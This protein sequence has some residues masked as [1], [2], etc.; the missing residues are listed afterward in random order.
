MLLVINRRAPGSYRCRERR[1]VISQKE[2][3]LYSKGQHIS[4]SMNQHFHDNRVRSKTTHRTR[5]AL[6]A[7]CGGEV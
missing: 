2:T 6:T 7:C 5:Q 3:Q 1:G 4:R